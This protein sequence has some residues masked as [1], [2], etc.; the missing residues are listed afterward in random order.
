M[1]FLKVEDSFRSNIFT[2]NKER[3]SYCCLRPYQVVRWT[4]QLKNFPYNR[5][6][7]CP[8]WIRRLQQNW[9]RNLLFEFTDSVQV[10]F[11]WK[12]IL[13][14]M[15]F[16]KLNHKLFNPMEIMWRKSFSGVVS[17][18][19]LEEKKIGMEFVTWSD[20]GI[21]TKKVPNQ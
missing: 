7:W 10:R 9:S 13:K 8:R 11:K 12:K 4:F 16:E 20:L 14:R 21:L 2:R 1:Q 3:S 17:F 19:K 6:F 18:T 5:R 15:I